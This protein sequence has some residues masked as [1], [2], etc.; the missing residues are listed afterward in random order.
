M[1]DKKA[2][3]AQYQRDFMARMEKK[4]FVQIKVWVKP[5]DAAK[6]K[7]FAEHLGDKSVT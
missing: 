6:V 7:N 2:K 5:R 1:K 4:G 3:N